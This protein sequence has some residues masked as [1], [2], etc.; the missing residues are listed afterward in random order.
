MHPWLKMLTTTHIYNFSQ[1]FAM[2]LSAP[3][4]PQFFKDQVDQVL[5]YADV[6]FGNESEAEAW[7]ASH[8]V[9]SKDL[10]VIAK[11]ISEF[12][13]ELPSSRPRRVIITH[14]ANSTILSSQGKTTV[15]PTPKINPS[16]IVD[17]NGAGDA[18]A[19]GVMGALIHG[20][21]VEE[22]ID[23][24]HKLGG[25]CIGQVG[26]ILKFRECDDALSAYTLHDLN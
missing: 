21:T 4:I 26:P 25:M 20:K 1:V 6:V 24:G 14:G 9:D 16:D 17:T 15:H 18:F 19:G 12:P 2:N 11:A 23:V 8:G 13:S 22:A 7:A 5:P 10:E 3:F